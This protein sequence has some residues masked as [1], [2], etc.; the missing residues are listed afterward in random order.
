MRGCGEG[1]QCAAEA[2]GPRGGGHL[3]RR[4]AQARPAGSPRMLG[5][6]LFFC[7][8]GRP[9]P[10]P[11]L[12]CPANL[13][14]IGGTW[15]SG[16]IGGGKAH[17]LGPRPGRR[18]ARRRAGTRGLPARSRWPHPLTSLT[19]PPLTPL[20]F[21]SSESGT[22]TKTAEE[23]QEACKKRKGCNAWLF[24]ASL[25]GCAPGPGDTCEAHLAAG[26]L[27]SRFGTFGAKGGD[28]DPCVGEDH[29]RY[30]PLMCALKKV[31]DSANPII[32]DP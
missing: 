10:Q 8:R 23:C 3:F 24:C 28:V 15:G 32:N 9:W 1:Q 14:P 2:A 19:P 6:P 7:A 29:A 30:P 21:F 25:D 11:G 31:P 26:K 27:A 17:L 16:L 20:F 5:R 4:L 13:R 18:E 12:S 22:G